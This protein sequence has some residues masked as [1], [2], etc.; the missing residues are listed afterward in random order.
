MPSVV[1]MPITSTCG[2]VIEL[3]VSVS[4]PGNAQNTPSVRIMT[5]LLSTGDQAPGA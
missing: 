4:G 5:M 2:V 3:G 1:P